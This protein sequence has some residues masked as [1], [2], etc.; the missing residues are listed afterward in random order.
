MD[1]GDNPSAVVCKLCGEA[2]TLPEAEAD[3]NLPRVLLCGHIYC[4][5]CL[6]SIQHGG[7]IKC[8]TCEVDSTLP[9]DGVDGLQEDSRII[10]LIYTA[11]INK[12][13]RYDGSKHR[14]SVKATPSKDINANVE[15]MVQRPHIEEIERT[16]DEA[17]AQAAENLA[18]LEHIHETLAAGLAQQVTRERVRL[19]TEIKQV[20]DMALHRVQKWRDLQLAKVESQFSISNAQV[21]HVQERLKSLQLA[22]QMAREIRRVPFLEQYC[23]LDKVLET[24]QAP[25]DK[26]SLEMSCITVDPTISYVLQSEEVNYSL[27]LFLKGEDNS[28]KHVSESPQSFSINPPGPNKEHKSSNTNPTESNMSTQQKHGGEISRA[29]APLPQGSTPRPHCRSSHSQHSS[30]SDLGSP[31]VIIEDFLDEKPEKALPPTGPELAND[32][33]KIRRGQKN[34]FFLNK[35]NVNPWVLVTHIVNPGH[36]YVRYVA[37]KTECENLY[38]KINNLCCSDDC[39]YTQNDT[40]ET[41][42]MIFVKRKKEVWCRASV[43]EV[44]QTGCEETVKSCRVNQLASIRVFLLDYGLTKNIYIQSEETNTES[45]LKAVNNHLRIVRESEVEVRLL[46]PQAIRC[47]LKDLVPYDLVKGWSK[48][49]QIEFQN[50][51]GNSPLEM[52]TLGKDKYSLLVDLKKT[53]MNQGSD[54]PLSV[55]EYLVF[56]E[57]ARFYYP[58]SMG[59]IPLL[60]YPPVR[61]KINTELSAVVSHINNPADFYVQL[62]DNMEYLLLSVKLQE[63]YNAK[64]MSGEDH[65]VYCPMEGQACVALCDDMWHRAVVKGQEESGKVEVQYVD[66]GNKE[67]VPFSDLRTIKDEFFALPSMAIHCCLSEVIPLDE[68]SWSGACTD[69][70]VSLAHK[71]VVTI[72]ATG[73]VPRTEPLPVKLFQSG[74]NGSQVNLAELLVSE[75]L[76]GFKEGVKSEPSTPTGGDSVIWDSPLELGSEQ[77]DVNALEQNGVVQVNYQLR[78]PAQLKDLKVKVNHVNSPSSFYVQFTHHDS[79]IKRLREQ[80]KAQCGCL[81]PQDVA[82]KVDMFCAAQ[83]NGVWERGRICSD[84]TSSDIAEVMLCDHGSTVKLHVSKLQ[85]LPSSLV[86]SLALECRLTDIRPAGGVSIWTATACDLLSNYLTGASATVTIQE[87][88]DER[89]VPV[90]LFC[91]NKI[92]QSVNMAEFLASEGLALKERKPSAVLPKPAPRTIM[93]AG[94]VTTSLY[95]PPE[96]PSHGHIKISVSAVGDDGLIY[97]RTHDAEHQLELLCE[98][99]QQSMK[100]LPRQKPYT[101]KSVQGCAVIGH[102]MLW[103][104]GQ[105]L[106][107]LSGHVKVQ[108]VDYGLIENIPVVHVYPMLLCDDVPQLCMPCQLHAINPVGGKWQPDAVALMRRAVLNCCVDMQVMELPTD[109]RRPITVEL[110]LDG[111]S[112][113]RILCHYEHALMDQSAAAKKERPGIS[114]PPLLD[115]WDINTEDLRITEELVLGPFVFPNLPQKGEQFQVKVKHLCTPNELFLWPLSGTYEVEVEGETL[116]E[117]LTTL[118]ENIDSLPRLTHFSPGSPCLAEYSDGKYYRARLVSVTSVEP[119]MI[120]VQHVDFGSHDT[121]PTSKLRQMPGKML[122]FPLRALKVKVVGFKAPRVNT[123]ENVLTYSP[124]WSVKAAMDMIDLL[125]SHITAL[126]VSTEPELKVQLYNSDGELVHLPLVQSGLA[127]LE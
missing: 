37:K 28:P 57:V 3:C 68:Q 21:S 66:F 58:V 73:M 4:T 124:A 99:I 77:E 114:L 15:D 43:V 121:L 113:S 107:V 78:F 90:T 70:L 59:T 64:A 19:E 103:Y 45:L 13:K 91:S 76:A 62:D 18:Q 101:W 32:K 51:I 87:L 40:V 94:N 67:V 2:F 22:M 56:I 46:P 48:K 29:K 36:F 97:A 104:R 34:Q 38:K 14:R 112:L 95:L 52:R 72:V 61:P 93:S 123:E 80:V 81:E 126:V 10:G 55:R 69:R 50:V 39:L 85:P 35:V 82:W 74:V 6:R 108:Y 102:D 53:P 49:A 71:K 96:L 42:S 63:C 30:G 1:R 116:D 120:L 44:V 60:Y 27:T 86:G 25:V 5:F 84:V 12:M 83:I 106:E 119:V 11:K 54:I 100:A 16:V 7:I 89:P 117:A 9:E 125:H 122:Q 20:S 109:P 79:K 118:N 8:P 98:R 33:W 88:T 31:D 111:I 127:E 24:L 65:Y 17:L 105:L 23:T 26:Q 92:G 110:F 41:E 47:S 115:E 75:Q